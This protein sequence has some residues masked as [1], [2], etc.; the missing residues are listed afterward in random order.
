MARKGR[1]R[2]SE[3]MGE[4]RR[5]IETEMS[6]RRLRQGDNSYGCNPT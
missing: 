5:G 1:R 3:V 2:A 4:G 6:I